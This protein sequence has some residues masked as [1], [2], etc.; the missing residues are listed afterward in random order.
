LLQPSALQLVD[1]FLEESPPAD[2]PGHFLAWLASRQPVFTH[3]MDGRRLDVG[4]LKNYQ[5]AEQWIQNAR[6]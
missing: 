4:N 5:H 1:R 2:A 6:F 3:Q